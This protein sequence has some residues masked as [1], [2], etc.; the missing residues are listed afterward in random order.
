VTWRSRG[1]AATFFIGAQLDA[2][3]DEEVAELERR[4]VSQYHRRQS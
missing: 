2:G 4:A 3:F 1:L